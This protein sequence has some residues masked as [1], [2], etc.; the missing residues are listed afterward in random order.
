MVATA[1]L[2]T[3]KGS[4]RTFCGRPF[5][6]APA[7]ADDCGACYAHKAFQAECRAAKGTTRPSIEPMVEVLLTSLYSVDLKTMPRLKTLMPER[8]HATLRRAFNHQLVVLDDTGRISL[9]EAGCAYLDLFAPAM[10]EEI[11]KLA[12]VA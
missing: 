7:H 10:A 1:H 9:D 11:S 8:L 12:G 4:G 3:K 5:T 2:E 6:I